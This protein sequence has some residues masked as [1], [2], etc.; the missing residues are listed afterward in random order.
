MKKNILKGKINFKRETREETKGISS[1][2]VSTQRRIVPH[3]MRRIMMVTMI[4][5]E[6]S[7]WK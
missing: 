6:C 5:K 4:Q 7:S 2:N 3:Q 1:R